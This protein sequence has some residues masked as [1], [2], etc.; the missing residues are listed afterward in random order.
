MAVSRLKR[1]LPDPVRRIDLHDLVMG[2]VDR[3][4][5][6]VRE[7]PLHIDRLDAAGFEQVQ[8]VIFEPSLRCSNCSPRGYGTTRRAS[9]TAC[10]RRFSSG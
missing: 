6:S 2:A 8:A 10:G 5:E 4:V 3:A 9:T 1:Y 7:Q